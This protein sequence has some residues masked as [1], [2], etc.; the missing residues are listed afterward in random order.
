LFIERYGYVSDESLL[1]PNHVP[2]GYLQPCFRPF[3]LPNP[4]A[5]NA[6]GERTERHP[7]TN[8]LALNTLQKHRLV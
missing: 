7:I 6:N 3:L 4:D 2:A 5:R 1:F 8:D